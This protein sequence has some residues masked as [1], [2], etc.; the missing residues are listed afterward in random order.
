MTR[1]PKQKAASRL[2][3][4]KT[5]V[6]PFDSMSCNYIWLV[7]FGS[8]G[9]AEESSKKRFV[10]IIAAWETGGKVQHRGSRYVRPNAVDSIPRG[11]LIPDQLRNEPICY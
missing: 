8:K 9:E 10:L 2:K 4:T 7:T 11:W 6:D 1:I 3:K 5:T